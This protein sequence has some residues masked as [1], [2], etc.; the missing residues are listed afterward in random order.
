MAKAVGWQGPHPLQG[1]VFSSPSLNNVYNF[2]SKTTE[3]LVL[4]E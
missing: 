3:I 4:L 1:N 2:S